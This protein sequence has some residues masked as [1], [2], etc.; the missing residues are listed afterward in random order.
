[1]YFWILQGCGSY[2]FGQSLFNQDTRTVN[3]LVDIRED[4][5]R[6]ELL[7]TFPCPPD[8]WALLCTDLVEKQQF[9]TSLSC[10]D[11]TNI[12]K[13]CL[14]QTH[15]EF[16]SSLLWGCKDR[17]TCKEFSSLCSEYSVYCID[18]Y[19]RDNVPPITINTENNEL[20]YNK[21]M[22]NTTGIVMKTGASD[23]ADLMLGSY[24]WHVLWVL[25]ILVYIF[26]FV[27]CF[28]NFVIKW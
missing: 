12:L 26:V 24:N 7:L 18:G 27:P 22:N 2:S 23:S 1:M 8:G 19:D 28:L 17:L 13:L 20:T 5:F 4:S 10:L 25:I 16:Y 3:Q 14:K 15:K 9:G 11:I 6:R 21:H